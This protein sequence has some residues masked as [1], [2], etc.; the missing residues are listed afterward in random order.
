MIDKT[1]IKIVKR[2]EAVAIGVKRTFSDPRN[3]PP[4]KVCP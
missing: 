2:T 3:Q 4:M 1:K